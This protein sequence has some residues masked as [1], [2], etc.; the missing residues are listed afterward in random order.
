MSI[1]Y[2][3]L[4]SSIEETALGGGWWYDIETH[5]LEWTTN[6]RAI[7]EVEQDYEPSIENAS[8]FYNEP[9]AQQIQEAI[10]LTA[11]TGSSYK[12]KASITTAKG[13]IK[14]LIVSGMANYKEN[15]LTA[16]YGAFQDISAEVTRAEELIKT[17][18]TTQI[19]LDSLVEGVVVINAAGKITKFNKAS[20]NIFKYHRKDIIGK[21]IETLMPEPYRSHHES[22]IQNYQK[23]KVAKIIGIGRE[24]IGIKADGSTFPM[25]LS[26]NSVDGPSGQ[27]FVGTIR[28]LT[29]EKQIQAQ[30]ERLSHYD[31]LTGLPNRVSL[32]NYLHNTDSAKVITLVAI[33]LH[34]FKKI[35]LAYDFAEGDFVLK[36]LAQ[37]LIDFTNVHHFAA[38]DIADRFWFVIDHTYIKDLESFII[39]LMSFLKQSITGNKS[40]HHINLCMGV[41]SSQNNDLLSNL[42]PRAETALFTAKQKG[43]NEICYFENLL[44]EQIISKY[45]IETDLRLAIGEQ[46]LECW[47]Q[48]KVNQNFETISAEV[49]VRWKGKDGHYIP[50]DKFIHIAEKTGLILPLGAYVANKTAQMLAQINLIKPDFTLAMN[51]SPIQ[52][53]QANFVSKLVSCF[54]TYQANLAN[55]TIEITETLL[56]SDI[57]IVTD[58]IEELGQYGIKISIDDFG[59]GHSNLKRIIDMPIFELKIDKQF[60]NNC[61]IDKKSEHLLSAIVSMSK[62]MDY[63]IVAEGVES[64]DIAKHCINLGVDILQGYYFGKAEP[65]PSFVKKFVEH[66]N[67]VELVT[68]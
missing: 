2:E 65:Y 37:R 11:M 24:V 21:P 25:H 31:S 8:T 40:K 35:N 22:Y 30:L 61:L 53:L 26:I 39:E 58:I 9:Y 57:K 51:V 59:T 55:L 67:T 7:H 50:P 41:A 62:V 12:M 18:D 19:T 64:L 38:K 20:E 10:Q 66:T 36:E 45:Q 15:K 29:E 34:D 43:V 27:G 54:H 33:N 68:A 63:S 56:I 42:I 47:L 14:W 49:L 23:T 6:L 44:V 32:I 48:P 4:M 60:V 1:S 52:F 28:D 46:I 17:K 5:V 16:I 13:N 3:K